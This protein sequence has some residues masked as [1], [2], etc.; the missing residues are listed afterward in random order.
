MKFIFLSNFFNHHQVELCDELF[1]LVNKDFLF[2][3]TEPMPQERVLLGYTKIYRNYVITFT[4]FYN[5]KDYY[6]KQ[7]NSCEI[8]MV[9]SVDISLIKTRIKNNGFIYK[10]SER[11]F[12]SKRDI[13]KFPLRVFK[14]KELG[15]N[16]YLLCASS[17]CKRDYNLLNLYKNRA[18]KFGY[19]PPFEEFN[20]HSHINSKRKSLSFLWCGRLINWKRPLLA[21]KFIKELKHKYKLDCCL[22]IVGDGPLKNK[23]L[24]TCKLFNINDN[25]KL[26]GSLPF[27]EIRNIMI[28]HQY[29]LFTS[30]RNEGWGA[31]L[32]E[33]MN[34]GCVCICCSQAGA[35]NYL[36]KDRVN[37][38][39]FKSSL[40]D[41]I[42]SFFIATKC[43]ENNIS[44]S[45]YLTIKNEWNAK[46]AAK[47]LLLLYECIKNGRAVPN[48]GPCSL[49]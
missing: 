38:F 48:D 11:L 43:N 44:R 23:L 42:K 17:F 13:I 33:A 8:L 34:S 37:G 16:S 32:N 3:E 36:I 25:V 26:I 5:N 7:I 20:N 2:I 18:Y 19:F 27:T 10:Y 39:I 4:E 47:R 40:K 41:L 15:N 49:A 22:T 9:G 1:V 46:F 28:A 31:V 29:F 35:S 12:K 24:K 30:N 45:A 21:L 14:T 6:Q